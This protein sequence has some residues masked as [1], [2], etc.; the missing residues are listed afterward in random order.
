[1]VNWKIVVGLALV[2]VGTLEIIFFDAVL[3]MA[4]GSLVVM[5]GALLTFLGYKQSRPE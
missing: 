2:T 1:M 3:M 4:M 5:V